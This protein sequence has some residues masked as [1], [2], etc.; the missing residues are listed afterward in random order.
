MTKLLLF[1]LLGSSSFIAFGPHFEICELVKNLGPEDPPLS[2]PQRGIMTSF[3]HAEVCWSG[4]SLQNN[5]S[6]ALSLRVSGVRCQ[7]SGKKNK[8]TET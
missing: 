6:Q 8:K 7:V 5:K 1:F 3:L 4:G 2:R